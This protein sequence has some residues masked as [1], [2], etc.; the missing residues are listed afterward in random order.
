MLPSADRW[1]MC[2]EEL[3]RATTQLTDVNDQLEVI[4]EQLSTRTDSVSDTGPLQRIRRCLHAAQLVAVCSFRM[5]AESLC[6]AVAGD[7]LVTVRAEIRRM[8]TQIRVAQ[9]HI[10]SHLLKRY[11]QMSVVEEGDASVSE[12]N[13]G[14]I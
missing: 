9:S 10:T 7:S 11:T 4:A 5:T 14:F 6:R 1:L 3:S 13:D 12:S 8:D 2:T